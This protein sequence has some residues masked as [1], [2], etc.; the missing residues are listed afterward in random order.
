[1][2]I[3]NNGTIY[4][5]EDDAQWLI[6]LLNEVKLKKKKIDE[7]DLLIC[8][9]SDLRFIS[10][11]DKIRVAAY[12]IEDIPYDIEAELEMVYKKALTE[13][14]DID[15][16]VDYYGDYDG[17]YRIYEGELRSF[18]SDRIAILE[19]GTDILKAELNRRNTDSEKTGFYINTPIGKLHAYPSTDPN[20]PGIYIDIKRTDDVYE[21]A[22]VL[23]EFVPEE[24]EADHSGNAIVTRV[25]SDSSKEDYTDRVI[26]TFK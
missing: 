26:H 2:T 8:Y 22:L 24:D 23:T 17:G 16:I 10:P 21:D 12:Y 6:A 15:I 13:H 18:D 4:V 19:A 7:T 5:R 3:N 14:K 11:R 1:M 9:A 20:H 25:W